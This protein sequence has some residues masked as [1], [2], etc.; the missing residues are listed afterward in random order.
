MVDIRHE[1]LCWFCENTQCKWMKK[2]AALEDWVADETDTEG[3]SYHVYECKEFIPSKR[4]VSNAYPKRIVGKV[5]PSRV[6]PACPTCGQC[7]Q[8]TDRFCRSCG[9]RIYWKGEKK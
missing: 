9:Q 5:V 6:T 1:S 8:R 3:G 4:S 2:T 7:V